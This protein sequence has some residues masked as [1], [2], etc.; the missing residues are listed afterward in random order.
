MV[1]FW[2]AANGRSHNKLFELLLLLLLLLDFKID[3]LSIPLSVT[4]YRF[5]ADQHKEKEANEIL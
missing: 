3:S 5:V 4:S 1:Y 2:S